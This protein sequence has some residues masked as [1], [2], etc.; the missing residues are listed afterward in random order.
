MSDDKD[1][2]SVMGFSGFG[3][4]L[5]YCNGDKLVNG[6]MFVTSREEICNEIRFRKTV[7]GH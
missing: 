3:K 5:P 6:I 4:T 7:R 2:Q 1:I